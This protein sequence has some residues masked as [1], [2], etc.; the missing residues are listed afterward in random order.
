MPPKLYFLFF[1][2][3]KK[4]KISEQ[5]GPRCRNCHLKVYFI[6]VKCTKV[7][8]YTES[9]GAYTLSPDYVIQFCYIMICYIYVNIS[10]RKPHINKFIIFIIFITFV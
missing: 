7:Y 9:A 8:I 6:K 1:A 5:R 10:E 2:L 4:A 3:F